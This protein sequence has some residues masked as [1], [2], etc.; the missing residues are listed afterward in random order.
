MKRFLIIDWGLMGDVLCTTPI[1]SII[2]KNHPDANITVITK[3]YAYEILK[4]NP[5]IDKILILNK[6]S[7]A[8]DTSSSSGWLNLVGLF[9][10]KFDYCIDLYGSQRSALM[11]FFSR[12]KEKITVHNYGNLMERLAYN[13]TILG[14]DSYALHGYIPSLC[15]KHN[16]RYETLQP[17]FYFSDAD[18]S[19]AEKRLVSESK[20]QVGIFVG[21]SWEAKRWP[22]VNVKELTEALK[23]EDIQFYIIFG[24]LE[25]EEFKR[26]CLGLF[27]DIPII[28][29]VSL[30]VL[31]ALIKSLD[32]LISN[33]SGPIHIAKAV[34]TT[35]IGL[36][37]PNHPEAVNLQGSS[38]AISGYE[39]CSLDR[40]K[41]KSCH[42][43][44]CRTFE[45]IKSIS[46]REVQDKLLKILFAQ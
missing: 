15:S 13:T 21:A 31:G 38:V 27:K 20:I 14:E 17:E 42:N 33:D 28:N 12:A 24:P 45:C 19:D 10:N 29:N 11:T 25:S 43:N 16:L 6:K 37:G 22:L 46:V 40:G 26:E 1:F 44:K 9:F 18:I 34:G 8:K 36:F 23:N 7:H 35:C 4:N 30:T 5:Y 3:P 32:M 39:N 41:T 2:K